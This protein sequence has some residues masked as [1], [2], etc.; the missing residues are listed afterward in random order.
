MSQILSLNRNEY[1]FDHHP[2]VIKALIPAYEEYGISHYAKPEDLL[3]LKQSLAEKL[4]VDANQIM[5]AH[6]AEDVFVKLLCH[7]KSSFNSV[8]VEDFSWTN[9]LHIAQG[10]SYHVVHISNIC[11]NDRFAFN[12]CG[13]KNYLENKDPAIVF[14]TSPNN[15]TGHSVSLTELHD[16]VNQFP[17]HTFILDSVYNEIFCKEYS[18]L[19]KLKNLILIGSFSKFFGMP[20]LRLGYAIGN[21]PKAFQL[22]LGLQP[23]AINAALAALFHID[24]YQSN[25]NEMLSFLEK[26]YQI[27]FKNIHIYKSNA[28]FFLAKIA[29]LTPEIS[30]Q[31][32]LHSGV[33]PKYILK[34]SEHFVRFGLGPNSVCERILKYF[35]VVEA[36]TKH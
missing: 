32:E 34:D 3:R 35:E 26:L 23:N 5:L 12:M 1:F 16:L 11:L 6:G 2:A 17:N 7:L 15:P 10:F 13:F 27:E 36:K 19:F 20:G 25:R 4:F 30:Q 31:A 33:R 24:W 8:V 28:P 9:Y 21:L 14:I 18:E 29:H 22:N